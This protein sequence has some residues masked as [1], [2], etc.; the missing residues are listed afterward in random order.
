MKKLFVRRPTWTIRYALTEVARLLDPRPVGT[1]RA[2]TQP[3]ALALAEATLPRR[4][5]LAA[6]EA[7]R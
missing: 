5:P 3:E 6:L 7:T 1:V 2:L 4:Y